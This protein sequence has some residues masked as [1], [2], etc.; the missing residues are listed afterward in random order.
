[1][2]T[3][4][5]IL[6]VI[7]VI[8]VTAIAISLSFFMHKPAEPVEYKNKI[9]M[10]KI[11]VGGRIK[12]P[13]PSYTGNTSVEVALSQ[14]RSIRNYSGENL[15]LDEVSQLLWAAQGITAPWGGRTAPSAGGLYPL[16][17]Y[18]VVGDV[19]GIDKGVYK[20]SREE[21]ELEKVKEGDIRAELA[22][23]AV[24]Q[25]CIRDAAIDIVFT[26]VYERTTRKYGERGIRYV[27]MEAGHAAQNVYL[28]AVSLD[29]GTVVIGA[30]I[31]DRVKELVNAGE[32]E[33]T[34]YIM[35]VGRKG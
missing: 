25:E 35:P 3:K 12:L 9:P 19:E 16:E 5:I 20:Y 17:L 18:V 32:Q 24:G 26:A 13:E 34:L 7:A 23:A 22:D 27:H 2:S 33:K 10:Q 31:D 6:W 1:M 11:E 15:T 21:H 28:Q 14:R 29:L 8:L 30:F 4:I